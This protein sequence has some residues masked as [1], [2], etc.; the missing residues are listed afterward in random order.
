[1]FKNTKK[2]KNAFLW[3]VFNQCKINIFNSPKQLYENTLHSFVYNPE[4]EMNHIEPNELCVSELE[5][6]KQ[7]NGCLYMKYYE[8]YCIFIF[9][10]RTLQ[11][12]GALSKT[13]NF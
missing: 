8:C 6:Y 7:E 10:N 9:L 12:Y 2:F 1:M 3:C 5:C 4:C 13:S 11:C